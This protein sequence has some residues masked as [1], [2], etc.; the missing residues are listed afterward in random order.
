MG[1]FPLYQVFSWARVGGCRRTGSQKSRT[2]VEETCFAHS[3]VEENRLVIALDAD[4]EAVDRQLA[5][6]LL[7]GNESPAALPRHQHQDGIGVV[8][9]LV[10]EVDAGVDLPQH[11]AREDAD[12]DM[13]RLRLAVGAGYYARL[14][15]VE[16]V[17]PRL[18]GGGAAEA[19]KFSVRPRPLAARMGVAALRVG[20]PDFDHGVVDRL[21]VA[22]QPR[23][24]AVDAP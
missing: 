18:V 4:I 13:R 23:A 16:A 20:L 2:N 15:C 6:R 7:V 3:D 8:C 17:D 5:A 22:V 10:G 1:S 14:D 21:A 11:A 19:G 9:R 24:L 12:H